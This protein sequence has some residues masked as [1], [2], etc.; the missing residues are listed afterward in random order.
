MSGDARPKQEEV[1]ALWQARRSL[2]AV[3]NHR[4]FAVPSAP[5]VTPGPRVVEAARIILRLLHPEL[6]P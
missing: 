5:F 2:K 6:A 4:V 1:L 3:A